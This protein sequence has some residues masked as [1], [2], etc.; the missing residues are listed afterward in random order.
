MVTD[1]WAMHNLCLPFNFSGLLIFSI[2]DMYIKQENIN[3][4][5]KYKFK[6]TG[7]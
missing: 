5:E 4:F 3:L 6:L 1:S 7:I 2:I